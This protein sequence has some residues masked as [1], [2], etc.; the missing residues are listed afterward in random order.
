MVEDVN[1]VRVYRHLLNEHSGDVYL[2]DL[3]NT[4]SCYI[5]D[6]NPELYEN[7]FDIFKILQEQD[8]I[9]SINGKY[10]VIMCKE[11]MI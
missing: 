8:L 5:L 2:H 10:R 9:K 3:L 1:F 11:L 7:S 6:N 4:V